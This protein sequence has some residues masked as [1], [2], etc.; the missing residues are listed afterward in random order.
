MHYTGQC[1]HGMPLGDRCAKCAESPMAEF[2]TV[3]I[4]NRELQ[5]G[6]EELTTLRAEIARLEEENKKL[7]EKLHQ[8]IDDPDCK[9]VFDTAYEFGPFG[10]TIK[11]TCISGA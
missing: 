8:C 7:R 1:S 9:K 2:T 3:K 11:R 10:L 5:A 4:I 6:T